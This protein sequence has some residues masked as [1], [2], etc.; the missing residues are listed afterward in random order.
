MAG[1]RSETSTTL[2]TPASTHHWPAQQRVIYGLPHREA[3]AKELERSHAQRVYVTTTRSLTD[4]SLVA[5][6]VA[7]LGDRFAGKFHDIAAHSPREAVIA[8][9]RAIR[10]A[11]ADSIVAVGGGSV[12]D[13][14][15]VML[16]ALWRGIES[17]DRLGELADRIPEASAWDDDPQ[18]LRM[19]AIPTTLSAAEFSPHAGIT[20]PARKV[21]E[22]F[23][24]PLAVP[25][26][27]I[28]DP[29]AT[30][31][32]PLELLLS[33]G[34]RAVDHAVEGYC[35]AR[36]APLAEATCLRAMQM[37]AASLPAI[38]RDPGDMAARLDAQLGMWLS[39][40][41]TMAGIPYGASHG[42][43]YLLGAFKG[44]PHG[45]TSCITLH[46]ALA[47][48][49]PVNADR[50]RAVAAAFGRPGE[51]ASTAVRAFVELLALPTRLGEIGIGRDELPAIAGSWD[52]G[53]PLAANPRPVRGTQDVIELLSL[54]L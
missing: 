23:Q 11:D 32:T 35:A 15:K 44:V 19:I 28:L 6:V 29:E 24:H 16:L 14:T 4:G 36:T 54:A 43:G 42:L 1:T 39:R 25:K 22:G 17:A 37:L 40:F 53:G 33:T 46:A 31:E 34:M 51:S 26:S 5:G 41:V 18:R 20:D 8:G 10:T 49:E 21:K 2:P 45:I 13:A 50:Q 27:V 9:A 48:N 12:I 30:R 47:W 38:K 3:L 52:G 7:G